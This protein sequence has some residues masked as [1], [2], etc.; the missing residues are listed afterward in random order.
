ME[1]GTLLGFREGVP[2]VIGPEGVK[3]GVFD[4]AV[5]EGNVDAAEKRGGGADGFGGAGRVQ[6]VPGDADTPHH[7]ALDGGAGTVVEVG[8][9]LVAGGE[10]GGTAVGPAVLDDSIGEE[11]GLGAAPDVVLFDKQAGIADEGLVLSVVGAT[12]DAR[13][14]TIRVIHPAVE[15]VTAAVGGDAVVAKPGGDDVAGDGL[16]A[17]TGEAGVIGGGGGAVVSGENSGLD[18]GEGGNPV[19]VGGGAG[20]GIVVTE[21]HEEGEVEL[22]EVADAMDVLGAAFGGGQGGQ[23]EGGQDGDDGDDDEEFDER[24]PPAVE[25][26]GAAGP[27]GCRSAGENHVVNNRPGSI[28]ALV[29]EGEEGGLL[30]DSGLA[31]KMVGFVGERLPEHG[32]NLGAF[33]PSQSAGRRG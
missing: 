28:P 11:D 27:G 13:D 24:E 1:S 19:A 33:A 6:T 31:R 4:M 7:L 20:D 26:T 12:T 25:R 15:E 23:Q 21:I 14:G 10:V 2:V 30:A 17:S 29:G 5:R 18:G 32:R 3:P 22:L 16:T 9:G 8:G